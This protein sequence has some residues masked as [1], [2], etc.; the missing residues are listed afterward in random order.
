M[1]FVTITL[2]PPAKQRIDLALPL[3]VPNHDLARAVAMAI[4]HPDKDTSGFLFSIKTEDGIVRL[5]LDSTLGEAGIVDGAV[6]L[7]QRGEGKTEPRS[8]RD[9]EAFLQSDS[10]AVFPLSEQQMLIGRRDIKR[11]VLVELDLTSYDSRKVVSRRHAS[12][13]KD[14]KEYYLVDLSSTTGTKVN[15]KRLTPNEKYCLKNNDLIEFGRD[16]V[17][18]KFIEKS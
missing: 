8:E 14:G 18:L 10:G 6:L 13:E 7:L 1:S 3:N 15:G 9:A 11:G 2:D 17:V 4:N 12:I 5:S 16:G